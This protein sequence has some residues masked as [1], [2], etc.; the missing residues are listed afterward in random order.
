[1]LRAWGIHILHGAE[2]DRPHDR[3][4]IIL[5]D[6]AHARLSR[7]MPVSHFLAPTQVVPGLS[8]SPDAPFSYGGLLKEFLGA[9]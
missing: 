7:Q 4:P 3:F 9:I 1:M 5:S 2:R 8:R 6:R